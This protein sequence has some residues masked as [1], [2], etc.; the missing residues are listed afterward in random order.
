MEIGLSHAE[1][2]LERFDLI[3]GCNEVLEHILR[4]MTRLEDGDVPLD[5]VNL[6]H[7]LAIFFLQ[8]QVLLDK[9]RHDFVL[10]QI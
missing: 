10:L 1:K 7:K 6:F 9:L 4:V 5:D 2:V 3:L 8:L